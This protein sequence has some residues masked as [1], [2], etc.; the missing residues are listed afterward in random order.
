[1]DVPET[2]L[3]LDTVTPPSYQYSRFSCECMGVIPRSSG[4]EIP[5]GDAVFGPTVCMR[6]RARGVTEGGAPACFDQ[7]FRRTRAKGASGGGLPI[8]GLR[9]PQG[10]ALKRASI[11]GTWNLAHGGIGAKTASLLLPSCMRSWGPGQQLSGAPIQL[12]SAEWSD[13]NQIFPEASD[14]ARVR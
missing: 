11:Q 6:S 12:Q 14:A 10:R 5:E 9:G 2:M 4:L 3:I 7:R 13:G 1:M 8:S